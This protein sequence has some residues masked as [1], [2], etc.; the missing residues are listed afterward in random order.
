MKNLS[1]AAKYY[2]FHSIL[3][4]VF[5]FFLFIFNASVPVIAVSVSAVIFFFFFTYIFYKREIIPGFNT[6]KK[7]SLEMKV[8]KEEVIANNFESKIAFL[9][10]LKKNLTGNPDSIANKDISDITESLALIIE[11]FIHELNIAKVFKVN[12]NEFLGNVAHE[13]RTPIFAI[14]LSIETLLEGAINDPNVNL[15]FLKRALGQIDRMKMMVDD[16][17][18]ISRLEAGMR[19]SKRYFAINALIEKTINELNELAENQKVEI[20]FTEKVKNNATV[21]GDIERIKQVV[22]NLI[23]NAI[24]NTPEKG[25]ITLSTF[26]RDKDVI[27]KVEDTGIGIPEKDLPRIFERFYRVDENRSR[28]FGGSGLG[29]SIVKHILELHNSQISVRSEVGKGT[30]FEFNLPSK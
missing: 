27:I 19:M 9:Q 12:R 20:I 5:L 3:F 25:L 24:K 11:R 15:N 4:V 18:S 2:L 21:F 23:E 1:A 16:L 28:D 10:E 14:Q 29:L 13:L 26:Y 17:I 7:S 8:K 30:I 22:I 6:V